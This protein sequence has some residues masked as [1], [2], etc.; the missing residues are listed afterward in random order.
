MYQ[1][2]KGNKRHVNLPS[3]GVLLR[4]PEL[5]EV[6][7]S[8]NGIPASARAKVA[9]LIHADLVPEKK[10]PSSQIEFKMT[11]YVDLI[12]YSTSIMFRG[13]STFTF[14][15]LGI[16]IYFLSKNNYCLQAHNSMG[17]LG[18]TTLNQT[19]LILGRKTY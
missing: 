5:H 8:R 6:T 15:L 11:F 1:E 2:S 19:Q 16:L 4:Y 18:S 9:A 13:S 10:I 12:T 14:A 17:T 3:R 7:R